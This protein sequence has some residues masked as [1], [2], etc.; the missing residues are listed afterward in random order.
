ML[1][2]SSSTRQILTLQVVELNKIGLIG[3][4]FTL[5]VNSV[6]P[7]TLDF[8]PAVNTST[9]LVWTSNGEN[10]KITV[11]S[12]SA[13][14]RFP[15]KLIPQKVTP[16]TGLLSNEVKFSDN[17]TH[18]L[19]VGLGKSAGRCEIQFAVTAGPEHG[20]GLETHVITFTITGS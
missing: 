3:S 15:L 20:I 6:D 9:T 10:K 4:N 16:A 2:Q 12:N 7:K 19:I 1:P 14:P 18:D 5:I 13:S 8:I 17:A 11:A